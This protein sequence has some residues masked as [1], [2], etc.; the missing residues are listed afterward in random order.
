MVVALVALI[1]RQVPQVDGWI[2]LAIVVL[3]SVGVAFMRVTP[4]TA[5]GIVEAS[6][7]ILILAA[8][9][10]AFANKLADR[11][12]PK[13]LTGGEPL[14]AGKAASVGDPGPELIKSAE[15]I[16]AKKEGGL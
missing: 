9:G 8:G 4:R 3:A 5:Q 12:A 16:V 10:N 11:A 2:A 15:A 1:R 7:S 14:V 6:I 13:T